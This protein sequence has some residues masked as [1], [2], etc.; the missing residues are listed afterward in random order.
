MV[1]NVNETVDY[2]GDRYTTIYIYIYIYVHG[3]WSIIG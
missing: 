2:W 1:V 3:V